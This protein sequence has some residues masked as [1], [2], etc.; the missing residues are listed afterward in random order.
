MDQF[1]GTLIIYIGIIFTTILIHKAVKKYGRD[2]VEDVVSKEKLEKVEK[3]IK[4]NPYKYENTLFL[5]Y[6]LPV[7]PKDFL[8]YIGSLLPITL[9]KFLA[10]TIIARFPAIISSTIA[11]ASIMSHDIKT[12]VL[13]YGI[14]YIVSFTIAFIFNRSSKRKKSIKKGIKV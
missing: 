8:T 2:L 5:L 13:V 11:G 1:G 7:V 12:I 6:F 9:K 10:V 14:T 3:K 4:E